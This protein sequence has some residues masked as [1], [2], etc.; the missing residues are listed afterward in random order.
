MDVTKTQEMENVFTEALDTSRIANNVKERL[1]EQKNR[2]MV[3]RKEQLY[4][5]KL[6][7]NKKLVVDELPA[8]NV[9]FIFRKLQEY[10]ENPPEELVQD[11]LE[12]NPEL[13]YE[14]AK[15][16]V[17]YDAIERYVA[18][19][20]RV[21]NMAFTI[22]NEPYTVETLCSILEQ[23]L[24]TLPED[25]IEAKFREREEH[26]DTNWRK[27]VQQISRKSFYTGD[28]ILTKSQKIQL[29]KR[30]ESPDMDCNR[31][32]EITYTFPYTGDVVVARQLTS[33]SQLSE[34]IEISNNHEAII[35]KE[36][37]EKVSSLKKSH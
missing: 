17:T 8:E 26:P 13:G 29:R 30:V 9:K 4:G 18:R 33:K 25:E 22:T 37:F 2:V 14:I 31:V 32:D 20:I 1:L 24:N 27:R 3:H 16:M 21:K 5:Y 7:E 11:V 19:E 6:D 34:T 10:S 12:E 28:L 23:P 36:L 35:S 15:T